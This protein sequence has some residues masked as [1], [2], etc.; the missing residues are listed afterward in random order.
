[1]TRRRRRILG[2]MSGAVGPRL[3]LSNA[4]IAE[5]AGIGDMVGT[6]SVVGGSGVYTFTITA[7]PDTKFA[8]DGD[9]L[10]LA[11][12]LDYETKSSHTVTIQADNGVD[13]TFERLFTISIIDVTEPTGPT[14]GIQ[15]ETGDF[16]LAEN[17]D[18][19]IQ[20]AA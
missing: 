11:A 5:D 18:Y 2:A 6:L 16:L 15:L 14:N 4:A 17:G 9:V 8:I 1:M 12:G 10:E 13:P 19:L 20:E 7:D 3:R